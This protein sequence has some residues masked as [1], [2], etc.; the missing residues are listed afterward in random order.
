M[1]TFLKARWQHLILLTYRVPAELLLPRLP[2]GLELDLWQGHPHVSLVAFDFR[3]TRVLGIGWPG[4]RHFPEINLRF[5]VR[6]GDKRGVV[7]I[8]EFVPVRLIAAA[9]RRFYNEPYL[10]APM[11]SAITA[12][13]SELRVRHALSFAGREHS[14][15]ILA[16][17]TRSVPA[18]DSAEHFFKE[19]QWGF[20]RWKN[21]RV[22]VY[23]VSHPVW[24]T[25]PVKQLNLE[26]N[27]AAVYGE[28]WA[29][30]ANAQPMNVML[31]AGS[32]VVVMRWGR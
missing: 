5:Y 13:G 4:M 27:W 10:A 32:A 31:A 17:Q 11:K 3:D 28:E 19:H 24:E 8:R 2:A 29:F 30:L 9:A 7:F 20:G 12:E 21:G 1:K 16:G 26:W 23:E 18:A 22:L 14:L 6:A 25:H 15:E